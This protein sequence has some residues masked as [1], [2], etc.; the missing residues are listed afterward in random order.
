MALL[1]G[2]LAVLA[3]WRSAAHPGRKQRQWWAGILVLDLI[4]VVLLL[5][6]VNG[7]SRPMSWT[8]ASCSWWPWRSG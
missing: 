3:F 1:L 8:V 4:V 2:L 6:E 7:W 5:I